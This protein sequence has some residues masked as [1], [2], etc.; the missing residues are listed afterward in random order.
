MK[1]FAT[2]LLT[3][4]LMGCAGTQKYEVRAD[5]QVCEDYNY[6]PAFCEIEDPEKA[7]KE[8][9]ETLGALTAIGITIFTLLSQ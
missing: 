2:I 7:H 8:R 4:T 9:I 5:P 6:D 3:I 1:L